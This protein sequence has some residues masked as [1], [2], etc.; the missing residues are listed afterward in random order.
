MQEG[1]NRLAKKCK[2]GQNI[3]D[4]PLFLQDVMLVL[5]WETDEDQL[6]AEIIEIRLKQTFTKGVC[7]IWGAWEIEKNYKGGRYVC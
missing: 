1:Y 3:L 7:S 5:Y 4:L 6:E 2:T